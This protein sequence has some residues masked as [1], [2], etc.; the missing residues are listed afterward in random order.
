ML[1]GRDCLTVL[2]T[3]GG[4]SVT[5]QLPALV[6]GS[7]TLVVSP[8]IALMR[9]QV[10]I[11]CPTGDVLLSKVSVAGVAAV[12]LGGEYVLRV[13]TET[14][15]DFTTYRLRI[16]ND[17][18]I[19]SYYNDVPFTFKAN[20]PSDLDCKPRPHECPP[21]PAVD[22]PV[23]YQARDFWSFR[24][25]LL[26]FPN[27]HLFRNNGKDLSVVRP[28]WWRRWVLG[29]TLQM[30]F[31]FSYI[32]F[33]HIPSREIVENYVREANRLLRPGGLFKFQVQGCASVEIRA[34]DSWEGVSFT[35]QEARE[36]AARSGFEM[37]YHHGAGE[38]Y[39]MLWFFKTKELA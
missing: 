37:R 11:W 15:G 10:V 12:K 2:P 7:M 29:R 32:V 24:R 26:D 1:G 8:L 28:G 35:E 38:Q 5:Y 14:P 3:G 31:V 4:K 30:D 21:E 13:T 33:Q 23:D 36:M 27:A 25:A 39:Y 20:C 18:R 17:T 9:D 16:D 22:F 34:G 6:S 19:D